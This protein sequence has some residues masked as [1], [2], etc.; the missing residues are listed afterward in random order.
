LL[1]ATPH[2]GYAQGFYS[3]LRLLDNARF[4]NPEHLDR[5][6]VQQ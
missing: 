4:P 3:L 1:T 5:D 6:T 2:N